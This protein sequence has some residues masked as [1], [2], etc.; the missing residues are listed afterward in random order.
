[1]PKQN[2]KA[3]NSQARQR[4]VAL[5]AS[6]LTLVLIA[7]ITAGMIVLST[8]DTNIS[9]NF[10]DEQRAY[11][12]AKAG[13]E[14]VRDRLR[15]NTTPSSDSI[16]ANV[17]TALPGNANSV[18]YILNPLNGETVAPW[19]TNYPDDEI[20]KENLATGGSITCTNGLPTGSGWYATVNAS[21]TYA[22]SPVLDW[23]WV[24]VTTKANNQ[25]SSFNVSGSA[26]TNPTYQAC[27]SPS[28]VSEYADSNPGCTSPN[29]PV[30]ILTALAVTPSGS[31]RMI[32]AEVAE[33]KLTFTAPS[34]LT[35]PGTVDTFN[36]GNANGW[37]VSGVDT[38]P[39]SQNP[40]AG[41]GSTS[42][43]GTV[44]AIGVP[45][46]ADQTLVDNGIPNGRVN[47]YPGTAAS[48]DVE[49]ISA[50]AQPNLQ[51][52][53]GLNQLVS[54][55]TANVT[56]PVINGNVS[57]SSLPNPGTAS[58]PQIIVVNGNVTISGNFTGY[59]ILVVTGS[60][61]NPGGTLTVSGNVNW[62]GLILVLGS[63]VFNSDGTSQYN[64]AILVAQT[65]DALGNYLSVLGPP[66]A[67]FNINGGGNGGVQYSTGCIAN[68][69]NLS[70]FHAMV[71]RELLH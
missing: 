19:S 36:G 64:G 59:G 12:S 16:R 8:T 29:L 33:D 21:S 27:W 7:A 68:A 54:T 70:T 40:T 58:A 63:G 62:N 57:L 24:R 13:M 50:T 30:Y 17:P 20:C 45:N 42:T 9:A 47:N 5:I 1:M 38:G 25:F 37:G 3:K 41:C 51:T 60:P 43:G 53:S 49:N 4:G 48:P 39:T 10:K 66:T 22:A 6:I 35:L 61:G 11:F 67:N 44:P 32:Q 31:R 34:A 14:E 71:T 69:T 52:V 56:Q 18:L 65:T 55:I 23:K 28:L 15:T 26:G 2:R 46:A